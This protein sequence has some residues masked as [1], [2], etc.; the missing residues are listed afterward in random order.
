LNGNSFG[1]DFNPVPDRI[2]LVSDGGQ[3]IRLN[4]NDGTVAGM[5]TA[6]PFAAGDANAGQTPAGLVGS[7][8]TNSFQGSTSTTLFGISPNLGVLARQGSV[9]GTPVS[10]NTGQLTTIGSLGVAANGGPLGFDIAT[11]TNA[12]FASITPQGGNQSQFY[13]INLVTGAATLI[14]AI[15]G[16]SEP[17][18]GIAIG[19]FSRSPGY[20]VCIQDDRDGSTLQ[21]DSCTGDFQITKCGRSGFLFTGKGD[22]SRVGNLLTLRADRVF[23]LVNISPTAQARSGLAVVK[24]GRVFTIND[25]DTTNNTCRCR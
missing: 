17:V 9:G 12:G 7:A 13:T 19:G 23:A 14:G 5:D 10:P 21:F 18:L 20:D 11:P 3:N 15:G 4:P 1:F 24:T 16:L 22:T 2:R 6:L 25:R 8:Y